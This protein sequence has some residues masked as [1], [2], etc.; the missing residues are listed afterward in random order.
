MTE[1]YLG[2][3]RRVTA[4][5]S[6]Q[7]D[8]LD[9][10]EKDGMSIKYDDGYIGWCPTDIFEQRNMPLTAL[11]FSGAIYALKAGFAIARRGWNGKGMFLTL[12][13]GSFDGEVLGFDGTEQPKADHQSSIDGIKLGLFELGDKGT[14]TRLPHIQMRTATG[15]LVNGWLDSQADLL[16][17]DWQVIDPNSLDE[18]YNKG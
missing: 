2:R 17:E 15:S 16:A 14:V 18:Q 3:N 10:V 4:W 11:D 12:V 5:P 13:K 1:D 8:K 6:R 7:V 9:N